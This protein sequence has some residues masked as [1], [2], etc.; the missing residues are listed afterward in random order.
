MIK[1][2]SFAHNINK[3]LKKRVSGCHSDEQLQVG[4]SI[5]DCIKF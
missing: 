3:D 5:M 2:N 1:I 4:Q